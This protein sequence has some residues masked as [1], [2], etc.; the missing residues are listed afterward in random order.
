MGLPSK[1]KS[2]SLTSKRE[3]LFKVEMVFFQFLIVFFANHVLPGIYVIDQTKLPHVGGD[4]LF[5]FILGVINSIICPFLQ[6]VKKTTFSKLFCVCF[7]LNF[8]GYAVLKIA[9]LGIQITSITGYFLAAGLVATGSFLINCFEM[10][11]KRGE[12]GFHLPE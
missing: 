12:Q 6:M 7:V 1:K 4:L 10:Q 9:P 3:N 2:C 8:L 11:E 5:A